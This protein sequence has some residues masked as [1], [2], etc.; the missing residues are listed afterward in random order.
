MSQQHTVNAQIVDECAQAFLE[1]I[2]REL[3]EGALDEVRML[4][5]DEAVNGLPGVK[6]ID[7]MN[8][9]SSMG[10]PWNKSKRNF[11]EDLGEFQFWRSYIKMSPEIQ[12]EVARI[13][14]SY[15]NGVRV[16][17]IFRGHQK[18]E[19]VSEAKVKA[20]K[21]RIFSGGNGPLAIVM[22]Q[23]YL[24][25]IR[26]IQ[27]NKTVFEAAP[28]TNATS[29]EWCH[30][31]HWLT[32]FGEDW[33]V[34]GDFKYFDKNQDPV[35][36]LA[37]FWILERILI[38]AGFPYEVMEEIIT[39]KYDICFPVTEFNGDFVGFWGSNPSGQI[40]TV[41]L[42]CIVN[43]LYMRYA[44]KTSGN[45][46]REFR[47]FVRLL[48]YG[49]DNVIGIN[50]EFKDVFNHCVIQAELAKIGVIYTMADKE[51]ESVPFLH[52]SQISFLKRSWVF[53]PDVGSYVARLEH[54]SIAKSL[55]MHLPSKTVCDQKLAC[56]S[57]YCA[58]L[59]YFNYGREKFE[60]KRTQFQA[61]IVKRE[62]E[63][64]AT[65]FPSYDELVGK[66]LANGAGVAPD[67]RCR[68]CN[69]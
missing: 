48:T 42:N 23:Y 25:L 13:R 6:Y 21:T 2:L 27:Q 51:A 53:N 39:N 17:P 18:D 4:S 9:N 30:F 68:V 12:R 1:D 36:M 55:L 57:M 59:E 61:V 29:V 8:L 31:Y 50:P 28:G 20:K 24:A 46:V 40:L 45:N 62:L 49:D 22:R 66:Y 64:Y 38:K 63:A 56:D 7:R 26:V 15:R 54:D 58:L 34:A 33:M 43:S 47:K 19:V 11:C 60:E 69:A 32:E 37:A 65:T 52:A 16:M 44:W 3:P 14:E 5:V 67:G 35:F 41:I 10:F